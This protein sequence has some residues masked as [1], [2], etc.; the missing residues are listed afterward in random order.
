MDRGGD[1]E[2]EGSIGSPPGPSLM[3]S[4]VLSLSVQL[5]PLTLWLPPTPHNYHSIICWHLWKD[6]LRKPASRYDRRLPAAYR[7]MYDGKQGGLTSPFYTQRNRTQNQTTFIHV[8]VVAATPA[9]LPSSW[10][11]QPLNWA[12][13][14][15]WLCGSRVNMRKASCRLHTCT[16][17]RL[18]QRRGSPQRK[19][20][21]F[22]RPWRPKRRPRRRSKHFPRTGRWIRCRTCRHPAMAWTGFAHIQLYRR[23]GW[24]GGRWGV[25]AMRRGLG[26]PPSPSRLSPLTLRPGLPGP[27]PA[28]AGGWGSLCHWLPQA[29]S[30]E[31]E[32]GRCPSRTD[33]GSLDGEWPGA[34]KGQMQPSIF[35]WWLL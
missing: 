18:C 30:A 3:G 2:N 20:P 32:P 27:G 33:S 19:R 12:D 35:F 15:W 5:F 7:R 17:C 14:L 13:R 11:G 22:G 21:Q 28:Q 9:F 16:G 8:L 4:R 25:W 29:P 6:G 31:S 1:S 34:D 23:S 26:K 24:P 10:S